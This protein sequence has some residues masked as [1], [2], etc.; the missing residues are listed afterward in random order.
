[1]GHTMNN[2][3]LGRC[4]VYN[5]VNLLRPK[6]K[7]TRIA[8][9]TRNLFSFIIHRLP[10][11]MEEL[12]LSKT[13]SWNESSQL[14]GG[15]IDLG[16]SDSAGAMVIRQIENNLR[17]SAKQRLKE[18]VNYSSAD[19]KLA[20]EIAEATSKAGIS[21]I[22]RT[23][24]YLDIYHACPELHWA[25]LAHMVS[26][27]AGYNMTDLRGSRSAELIEEEN[28]RWCYRFLE[29]SNALIFQDAYPQLLLYLRSRELGSSQFHLLPYFH[30]S[31]FMRPFWDQF[32]IDR[33]SALLTVGLIINEQNYIEKRV[34]QNPAYQR[35]VT[36]KA[37]FRLYSLSGL[38]QVVFP[39]L[40]QEQLTGN[41]GRGETGGGVLSETGGAGRSEGGSGRHEEASGKGRCKV[42]GERGGRGD[43]DGGRRCG[44]TDGGERVEASGVGPGGVS[45]DRR[46]EVGD[47]GNIIHGG[48]R[49]AGRTVSDFNSL[50]AR[51]ALGKSLYAMLM[52]LAAVRSG[53]ERFAERVPHT[54]SRAD[55][56]PEL[57]TANREE[58]LTC[59]RQGSELLKH[60]TLPAGQRLYSPKLLDAWGNTVYEPISREDWLVDTSALSSISAPK[61]PFLCDISREHRNGILKTALAHDAAV[62]P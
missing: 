1:M 10:S 44:G 14:R 58:A 13:E 3:L 6:S 35:H 51:I 46:D 59:P 52:G 55:Y 40:E 43:E 25:F 61:P 32:W 36:H 33:G 56:W 53:A 19:L 34:V 22:T 27:N 54:G 11:I 29:R 26:R 57:F 50:D 39:M 47:S 8:K 42:S 2:I 7:D 45:S 37:N 4:Y 31:E 12:L 15:Q 17:R 62:S 5:E 49:L 20:G 60:Q 18:D 48:I 41:E 23:K 21:N 30:V 28:I 9:L 24:A 38:N 16:W